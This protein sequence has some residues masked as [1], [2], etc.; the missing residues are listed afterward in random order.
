MRRR[1]CHKLYASVGWS[2]RGSKPS[3]RGASVRGL[4][5]CQLSNFPGQSGST[6]GAYAA[7]KSY[8]AGFSMV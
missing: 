2:G 8:I 4:E 1:Y 7:Q 5:Y 6:S 3:V